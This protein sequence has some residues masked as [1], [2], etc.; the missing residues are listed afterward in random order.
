MTIVSR[1][2]PPALAAV[3]AALDPRDRV[4]VAD[5][6]TQ[7]ARLLASEPVV[8]VLVI[9]P[10]VDA[11]AAAAQLGAVLARP[12]R[13][14]VVVYT[15]LTPAGAHRALA[16]AQYGVRLVAF[17]GYDDTP[18]S[19]RA[20]LRTAAASRASER[21]V[22][23]LAAQI[24]RLPR[25]LAG[26]VVQLLRSPAQITT[27]GEMARVAQLTQRSI[28][29][30]LARAGIASAKR[31][32][33]GARTV[34]AYELLQNRAL[35]VESVAM[36]FGCRSARRFARQVASVAGRPPSRLWRE[37]DAD[38]FVARVAAQ[39]TRT[40]TAP[41]TRARGSCGGR[42]QSERGPSTAR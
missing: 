41:P 24:S 20:L 8:D 25:P 33:D 10:C 19:L 30:W 39:L 1:L 17:R 38:A 26:A 23:Y 21:L 29:R 6:P 27:V 5:G 7:L 42:S 11:P 31:L 36:M 4:I 2:P 12:R 15:A 28:N 13:V 18:C 22:D 3:R 34:T 35:R 37:V 32:V 40:S 14:P 9:D 16:L